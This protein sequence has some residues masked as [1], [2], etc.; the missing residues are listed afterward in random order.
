MKKLLILSGLV[1]SLAAPALADKKVKST[2]TRAEQSNSQQSATTPATTTTYDGTTGETAVAPTTPATDTAFTQDSATTTSQYTETDEKPRI[3]K[4]GFYIEP[5]VSAIREDSNLNS[6][7]LGA[8]TSGT[9]EGYGAGLRI[10]GHVSEVLFLGVDGRYAKMK[11]SDNFYDKSASN[12]YNVAPMLGVQTPIWGIRLLAGYVLLGENSFDANNQGVK[13][14]FT[15]PR[16][17]RLGA[18]LHAGPVGINLE[19]QDL[20]YNKAEVQSLGSVASNTN[21][22][23][24]DESTKG[25]ALSLSF[26]IEL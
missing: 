10:G 19:Y 26:P 12:V 24:I 23:D 20:K 14:K 16:G 7:G 22:S 5:M 1:L 3:S 17:W 2:T 8:N 21:V 18:G 6:R 11:Q 15:E 9:S 13:L 4:G 25:Y